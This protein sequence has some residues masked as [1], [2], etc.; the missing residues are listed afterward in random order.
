MRRYAVISDIH[1]NLHALEAVLAEIARMGISKIICLGDVV[2]Y[3]PFPDRCIDL[4]IKCCST[5]IRGNHDDA[6]IN[7]QLE[8]EFN[9]PAK[10]AIAWSRGVLGPLHLDA[11]CRL[12]EI[13]H[14]HE[15][16]MCVHD[17]PVT[18]ATDY[19]Y[20]THIAA[21]AFGGVN[22]PICLLGHT[23]VPMVFE[24]PP[25]DD[26]KGQLTA[27]DVVAY[28]TPDGEPI[29]LAQN[30]RYICNPGSVGQPRD[31]DPRASFAVLDLD[32][33]TFTVHRRDYDIDAAQLATQQ[34]GLPTV[35]ADRLA[36]GA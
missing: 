4:V 13:E 16:V 10:V 35:L 22:T 7:P 12:R 28:V 9:G 30:R 34:A 11:L 1:G 24:A 8:E 18:A 26:S 32:Q 6:V 27:R 29:A 23:H 31:A 25:S 36:I 14:P 19:V 15:S 21:I 17:C 3:G 5:A 20:D 2:G 33:R